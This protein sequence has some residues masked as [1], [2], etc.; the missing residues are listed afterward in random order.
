MDVIYFIGDLL[1]VRVL[2]E[3]K[4][5]HGLST[6]EGLHNSFVAVKDLFEVELCLILKEPKG[7]ESLLPSGSVDL[8]VS[9]NNLDFTE[10]EA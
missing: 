10:V 7:N 6:V 9:F 1:A 4:L 2:W 8:W 5:V 3:L